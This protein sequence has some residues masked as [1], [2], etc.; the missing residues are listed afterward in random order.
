MYGHLNFRKK[1]WHDKSQ[2]FRIRF[3]IIRYIFLLHSSEFVTLSRLKIILIWILGYM[4]LPKNDTV[5]MGTTFPRITED[6][7]LPTSDYKS[8]PLFKE[9]ILEIP[10]TW[11]SFTGNS[12]WIGAIVTYLRI[13]TDSAALLL[14]T[15]HYLSALASCHFLTRG[16]ACTH[17]ISAMC[18]PTTNQSAETLITSYSLW[19]SSTRASKVQKTRLDRNW[20]STHNKD[21][22]LEPNPQK[23]EVAV[24]HFC[25]QE[26]KRKLNIYCRGSKHP[27]YRK[28]LLEYTKVNI[29]AAEQTLSEILAAAPGE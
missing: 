1:K 6:S 21:N 24:S 18:I 3:N 8:D 23:T 12:R 9:L 17:L 10:S 20:I 14:Y 25:Y 15:Q 5:Y 27:K 28:I 16:T 22:K 13:T 29:L 4:D 2:L 26:A 11:S 19:L 7:P